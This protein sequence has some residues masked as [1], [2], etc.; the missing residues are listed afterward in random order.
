MPRPPLVLHTASE[1]LDLFGRA[2]E[3]ALL[4]AALAA[5]KLAEVLRRER[6]AVV[7]D[8][9]EVVQHEDGPW[10]GRFTHPDLGML[11]AD[12]ASEPTPGVVALTSRF[13]MPEL[14]HRP[15]FAAVELDR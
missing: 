14:A 2:D 5:Q 15:F 3:L 1:P 13:D 10:R 12:L 4:D 6:W 8:G 9:A 7:L 11:L